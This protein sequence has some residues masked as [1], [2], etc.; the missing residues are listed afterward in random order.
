MEMLRGSKI[1]FAQ[2]QAEVEREADVRGN[3]FSIF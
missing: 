2:W 1:P 3:G